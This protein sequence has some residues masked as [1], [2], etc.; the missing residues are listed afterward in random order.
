V[1]VPHVPLYAPALAYPWIHRRFTTTLLAAPHPGL[2]V[3]SGHRYPLAACTAKTSPQYPTI[4]RVLGQGTTAG[5]AGY[6]RPAVQ[7]AHRAGLPFVLTEFNSVTCGGLPGVSNTFATAL[8]APDAAFELLR[9]GAVGIH[10]HA[11]QYAI[12]DPFTFDRDGVVVRPLLYGLILF[13]R[14]L[15]PNSRLVA[16]RLHSD[17][18]PHLKAWAVEVRGDILHV[19]LLNKGAITRRVALD[20]PATAPATVERL[21]APSVRSSS[22]V[23]LGGQ[24]L[25][26]DARWKGR[27]VRTVIVPTHHLYEVGLPAYSAALVTAHIRSGSLEPRSGRRGRHTP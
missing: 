21:L 15:G 22:N 10:L 19:L 6:V 17:A 14:T 3:I 24:W 2:R 8:W 7:L 11:R 1:A 12:N 25:D 9:T 27:A 13:A 26:S 20:L 18:A 5:L 16:L 4:A 23:T